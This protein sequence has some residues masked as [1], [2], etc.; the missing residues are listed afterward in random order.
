MKSVVVY[1]S[2][3]G[4]TRLVAEAIADGLGAEVVPVIDA[5]RA[6]LAG[7]DLVVL[8]GPTHMWG[9][10]R[11]KT[12]NAAADTAE[13]PGSGETLEPGATGPGLREWLS[14]HAAELPAAVAFDTRLKARAIFTGRASRRIDKELRRARV[15]RPAPPRSF[16]VTKANTL[17]PGE[18]QRAGA[19][20]RELASWP[21]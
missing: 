9:L 12:R 13:K 2:M 14:E 11:E 1:E 3:F 5:N 21:G 8:G 20:G 19:W 18:L 15:R 4:N 16:F 6:R 17:C 7:A 10:S